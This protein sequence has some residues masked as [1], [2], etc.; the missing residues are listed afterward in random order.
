[1]SPVTRQI[2]PHTREKEGQVASTSAEAMVGEKP[3]D[4]AEVP[5]KTKTDDK[6]ISRNL[7][8]HNDGEVA[9][10]KTFQRE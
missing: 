10:G 4:P 2:E 3:P 1:M 9:S 5:F 6:K 7:D 8:D